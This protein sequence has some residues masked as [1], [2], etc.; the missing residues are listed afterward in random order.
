MADVAIVS[1]S[2]S[3]VPK[4]YTLASG[5]ELLLKAV[6]ATVDGSGATVAFLPALQILAP[7]GTVMWEGV[8][9][10]SIA[11][12]GTADVSWFPDVEGGFSG[13]AQTS[14]SFY[15]DSRSSGGATSSMVL[16][17]G[18]TYI[19]TATG[20]W[21][22]Q[23][24]ALDVGTP[25]ANAVYPTDPS[26]RVSTQVGFDPE[27]LYAYWSAFPPGIPIG[28]SALW[29][30]NLGSGFVHI[31]PSDGAHSVPVAG[32]SYSYQVVGEGAPLSAKFLD[33]PAAYG[34]N[35]GYILVTIQLLAATDVPSV[36]PSGSILRAQSGTT[37]WQSQP[38]ITESD[39]SLSNVTT[40][41]V[42]T[43]R[44]GFAPKAPNDATKFLNGVGAYST[45]AG[46]GT[47]SDITSTGGSL[48]VGSPAGPT[49]NV[50]VAN[51]GVTG[52]S[53]GDA[54]H[55]AA[56]TVGAD[57]RITAASSVGIAGGSGTIGFEIG[58]DQI[59]A[60]VNV[61][62]TTEGGATTI[63]TCAAHT[64]DGAAV[65]LTFSSPGILVPNTA[66][67]FVDVVLT[68]SGTALGQIGYIQNPAAGG[69]NGTPVNLTYRFTPSAGSHTYVIKAFCSS[70]S[71]T[72]R[73][74]AGAAGAGAFAPAYARFTKV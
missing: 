5:E 36:G 9:S 22:Y 40:A 30:M 58:Y 35:Y 38:D 56:I 10:T 67:G 51:S 2:T 68:E 73:V 6:R 15:V 21:S 45:P 16:Q 37:Q 4:D 46:G 47:I 25:D 13:T 8:P 65:L 61:T 31:E 71:G 64:F 17:S 34:D 49:T 19:V 59:T 20:S 18:Q 32:H 53:Y 1:R 12:G 33:D 43:T 26:G 66:G 44:H 39:L 28:H 74:I 72:P 70:T 7:D 29:V 11:V 54:S 69:Q 52:G 63:I 27:T 55:V 3:A 42:S 23:N 48:T 60:T 57:G 62:G 24:H 50:D 41:D 14:D